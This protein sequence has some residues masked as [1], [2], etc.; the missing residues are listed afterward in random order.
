MCFKTHMLGKIIYYKTHT[1]RICRREIEFAQQN[2]KDMCFK[3][4]IFKKNS[5][6]RLFFLQNDLFSRLDYSESV[7][8][9]KF[10]RFVIF[11]AEYRAVLSIV[12][13]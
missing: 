11:T 1:V 9:V 3:T 7:I 4:H 13:P 12:R 5:P 6:T 2:F 10:K 8:F